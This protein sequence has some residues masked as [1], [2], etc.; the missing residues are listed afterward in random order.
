MPAAR[1]GGH[2]R[3]GARQGLLDIEKVVP[4]L[5]RDCPDVKRR[6]DILQGD[7]NAAELTSQKPEG[8]PGLAAAISRSTN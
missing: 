7:G 4:T 2:E 8:R 5:A 1:G 3:R 6:L